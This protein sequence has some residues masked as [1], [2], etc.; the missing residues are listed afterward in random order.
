MRVFV[1]VL[2]D[3]AP[4][5]GAGAYWQGAPWQYCRIAAKASAGFYVSAQL[6]TPG[7]GEL[8]LPLHPDFSGVVTEIGENATAADVD[9]ILQHRVPNIRKMS[10]SDIAAQDGAFNLYS[11][12]Y[13]AVIPNDASAAQIGIGTYDA[14][15]ADANTPLDDG[16][17]FDNGAFP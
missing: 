13:G 4:G 12:T 7:G 14:I 5:V 9:V 10:Y 17:G 16:A 8:P 15:F 11:M 3:N 2:G 1:L 6:D